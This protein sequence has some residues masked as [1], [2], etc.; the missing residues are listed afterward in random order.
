MI[1]KNYLNHKLNN[2]SINNIELSSYYIC[3]KC[4]SHIWYQD[5]DISVYNAL[6]V[7]YEYYYNHNNNGIYVWLKLQL[8]CDEMIIKG[9]I[10]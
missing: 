8:T 9:I 6:M 2:T 5:P 7:S 4:N 1:N 10:E 3:E